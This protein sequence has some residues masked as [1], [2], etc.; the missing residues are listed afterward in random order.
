MHVDP[1]RGMLAVGRLIQPRL[2]LVHPVNENNIDTMTLG[3][4]R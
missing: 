2:F 1:V 4:R 3:A